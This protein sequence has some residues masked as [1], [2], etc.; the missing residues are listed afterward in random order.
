M[1]PVRLVVVMAFNRNGDGERSEAFTPMAFARHTRC[2]G[3]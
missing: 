3:A 1:A 2:A